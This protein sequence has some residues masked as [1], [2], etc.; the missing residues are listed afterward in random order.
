MSDHPGYFGGSTVRDGKVR[1]L[2][3][4]NFKDLLAG[5]V[6][7]PVHLN[8]TRKE[9]L[10]HPE[11]NTIKD[12]PWLSPCA[13]PY[14]T[15]GQ[16]GNAHATQQVLLAIDF[17]GGKLAA[18]L[19]RD[20]EAL[21]MHLHGL[22]FA[23][24]RTASYTKQD[25]H[26]RLLIEV[27][28]FDPV[29]LRRFIRT[30]SVLVGATEDFK[31]LTESSTVSQPAYR[32][33]KFKDEEFTAVIASRTD[34]RPMRE[35]DLVDEDEEVDEMLGNRR[36]GVRGVEIGD[37]GIE[38]TPLASVTLEDVEDALSAI[39]PDCNRATWLKVGMALRHQFYE[40]DD[41]RRAYDLY[42]E[43]SS[44][45]DKYGGQKETWALWKSCKP[46]ADG[47]APVTIKSLFQLALNAGWDSAK[48]SG[49]HRVSVD[50]WMDA[51]EDPEEL[52][53]EG[54]SRIISL[55]FRNDIVEEDLVLRLQNKLKALT[56]RK[57]DK[58]VVYAEM[59]KAR[60]REKAEKGE[61]LSVDPPP[62][63][64]PIA[65][66]ASINQFHNFANGM[67]Y[68]PE[69]FNNTFSVELMPKDGAETPANARPVMSASDF[70]RNVV[71]IPIADD[72]MYN[73]LHQGEDPFFNLDGKRYLNLYNPMTVPIANPD[74]ADEAGALLTRLVDAII[75]EDEYRSVF[76]DYL[77]VMVKWPGRKV[78]WAPLIQSAEGAG[79]NYLG[80]I[81]EGVIGAPNV[82]IVD[83]TV[84]CDGW[85]DFH[86]QG[87]VT[88]IIN[89]L[90]I[91]GE[92]RERITNAIK[93]LITD[94]VISIKEKYRSARNIPNFVNYIVFTNYRDAIHLKPS[95][96]R[97][98]VIFSKLQ[99]KGQIAALTATGI[100]KDL[101]ALLGELSGSLRWWLLHREIAA[102]FPFNGPPPAT[103]YRQMVIDDSTNPLQDAVETVIEQGGDPM[104]QDDVLSHWHLCKALPPEFRNQ[105]G[106]VPHYLHA[107]G[108]E[109]VRGVQHCN[110]TR[111][112]I[113]VHLD[114]FVPGIG[115]PSELLQ[116]RGEAAGSIADV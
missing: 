26:L 78:L 79:K 76:L 40:E 94:R 3:A 109:K 22:N 96:R 28:P 9:F 71:K 43:W 103:K 10:A 7:V 111:S 116:W 85:N 52:M 112:D 39:D 110:G 11:K 44:R 60:R 81:F 41:A 53:Q 84:I 104:V 67:R 73:P 21:R 57:P 24:W 113:W 102:D 37:L 8:L 87:C 99:T 20:P 68:T 70:A 47:R 49:R 6:N 106:R 48:V 45:G 59:G 33:V 34:G 2:Q 56:G 64:R 62:W 86:T 61:K 5:W 17:D 30:V 107:L 51:C 105:H 80:N 93:P 101:E 25:P 4:A 95:D 23:C 114:R 27:E 90:H 91:P 108:Y 66:V 42:D 50:E 46:Y 29:L 13:Y 18:A 82:R 35:S 54:P 31:G 75:A 63:L 36:Y 98:F 92:R 14:E 15:E 16:R 74:R 32:P 88:C 83:A 77:A 38:F 58:R 100:F 115:S 19:D 72:V 65:F 97:W 12:G 89:E 55:P 1:R 69:A